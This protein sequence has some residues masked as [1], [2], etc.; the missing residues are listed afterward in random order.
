MQP[1]MT[2]FIGVRHVT[3]SLNLGCIGPLSFVPSGGVGQICCYL[4]HINFQMLRST[5]PT[6]PLLPFLYPFL[7]VSQNL[8]QKSE[9][10]IKSEAYKPIKCTCLITLLL[11]NIVNANYPSEFLDVDK[12]IIII[13]WTGL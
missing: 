3:S 10:G 8:Q 7:P 9:G 2:Y 11:R 1:K 12:L 13:R 5:Y 6:P 4:H